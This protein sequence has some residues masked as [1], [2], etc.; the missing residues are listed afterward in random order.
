MTGPLHPYSRT[1]LRR[2]A[3]AWIA[4]A[5]GFLGASGFAADSTIP[6]TSAGESVPIVNTAPLDAAPVKKA[7]IKDPV[8]S[9]IDRLHESKKNEADGPDTGG[10]DV[11]ELGDSPDVMP[12]A[13]PRGKWN[14]AA[15]ENA[16]P[17]D[18]HDAVSPPKHDPVPDDP[19]FVRHPSA[20]EE[21]AD[22]SAKPGAPTGQ[23]GSS[24]SSK[25]FVPRR[26]DPELLWRRGANS[27]DEPEEAATLNAPN[28][29]HEP[30][31]VKLDRPRFR[32]GEGLDSDAAEIVS[33]MALQ[34][35]KK[36]ETAKE[37]GTL[38]AESTSALARVQARTAEK[39]A[40][41][42]D[43][44]EHPEGDKPAV[45]K[46]QKK[47]PKKPEKKVDPEQAY[48]DV[49]TQIEKDKPRQEK[50][51]EEARKQYEER[52]AKFGDLRPRDDRA[53]MV[54]DVLSRKAEL[55]TVSGRI[56]DATTKLPVC[57][58]V[59]LVDMT[60]VA[61][62]A[63]L[64]EGFWTNGEFTAQ[65]LAGLAKIEITRGRF[66]PMYVERVET[67]KTLITPFEKAV[68]CPPNYD[69]ATKGWY[70]ADL[71]IGATAQRREQPIWMGPKPNISDLVRAA[72]AEGIQILGVPAPWGD[73][74]DAN[75]ITALNRYPSA[76]VLLVP[77][78][79]GPEH[80]FHGCAMGLGVRTVRGLP[81]EISDP[82]IPLR[83]TFEDIR[84]RGG[85]GV[86]RLLN[87]I[88]TVNI[89][90]EVF[91][92]FPRLEEANYFGAT[93]GNARLYGAFEL[94]F[95]T[96]A[97]PAYDL[98]AFD[99]S[100]QSERLWFNLLDHGYPVSIIGAGGGSLEGGRIPFGQTFINLTEK[101]RVD[102]VLQAIK[103]GRTVVSFGPAAFCKIAERDMGPGSILP[104]DGRSLTLSVQAFASL[105]NDMQ[106]DKIEVIRNGNV[107]HTH[108][109]NDGETEIHQMAVPVSETSS[110]WYVVRVTERPARRESTLK[111]GTTW[112]SP[113]YF[114][115]PGYAPP[116]PAKS[117][118]TGVLRI[119][120]TPTA[121]T[122]KAVVPG[123]PDHLVQTDANGR[124]SIDVA[125]AGTLIFEAP[126]AEPVAKRIF[127]HPKVQQAIG[128]L[129][130]ERNGRLTDQFERPALF[131]AWTLLLS[132]L[133]WDI[134]LKPISN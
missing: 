43:K 130:S 44:P 9:I 39:P 61:V 113:I 65:P 40:Q 84:A 88:R 103:S 125:A 54:L 72:Q 116:T 73:G 127:E 22:D 50:L 28:D 51:L 87:G 80:P 132:E 109:V 55:G 27:A 59:R 56:I 93:E 29:S 129:Q 69:F 134:S 79:A 81:A 18:T 110:A 95:D 2:V 58:R 49:I 100:E 121:G 48:N 101:P 62:D 10:A 38:S 67:K 78:F 128:A 14:V 115:G 30:R 133:D 66:R 105:A 21:T 20:P 12:A 47:D 15:E 36:E 6:V 117:K 106:L 5:C 83:E 41:P 97:G 92:L 98:L 102:N 99:G 119:G 122:V 64:T 91:P 118:I 90:T 16:P 17:G 25:P 124:F 107:I 33:E 104:A 86:F 31:I 114:R 120:A 35:Q 26:D 42:A 82:E 85:L 34:E 60:D 94:P 3:H 68:A 37:L 89:R 108:T 23:S 45:A 1:P 112:T 76:K 77:L 71:N 63:P 19:E 123:Q 13:N 126:H 32:S 4:G 46:K 53:A 57:A 7:R 75:D 52:R 74:A 111:G 8:L 11:V 24:V 131:G 96:V 70:L